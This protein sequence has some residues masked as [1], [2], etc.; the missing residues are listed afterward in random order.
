MRNPMPNASLKDTDSPRAR[1]RVAPYALLACL[2]IGGITAS[3]AQADRAVAASRFY[4]DALVRY[5]RR[6]D[7]GA[8]IQ[9]KNALKEDARMLPALVLLGQAHGRR[10]EYAAAER[11]LADAERLGV[12]RAQIVVHQAEAYFGQGKFRAL[13]EKFGADGLPAAPRLEILLLRAQSQM[14]LNQLDS[15]LGSAQAAEA[16]AGGAARALALQARIHLNAGRPQQAQDSVARAL[17]RAPQDADAWNMQASIAHAAGNLEQALQGYGRALASQPDHLDAR[18]ARAGLLLDLNRDREAW[19]DLEHLQKK[20]A[21]DPRSAYLRALYHSR[22]G[23]EAPA[24]EALVEATRTLSQLPAE[25]VASRDQLQL[26]GGLAHFALNEFE[27]AKGYL[28]Q[29][30][31]VRPREVGARKVLG[32]IYLSEKQYDRAL[33]MLEP[34]LK[35]QPEDAR[36]LS[37]LGSAHMGKGN[38]VRA[39]SLFQEAAQAKDS[40]D[41]QLGLGLSLIGRGQQ[42][43][44]FAA[45]QRAYGQ[46]PGQA[47]TGAPL[48][49]THL[50]RGE[51]GKAVAVMEAVLKREPRNLSARNL[52]G[53]ARLA[54]GDRAGARAAY[55]AVIKASPSFHA[56]QLN[57]GRLDEAEGHAP[58]ARQ[59]YLGVL[60]TDPKHV[61]AMLELARLEETAGRSAEAVRWLEKARSLQARDL[62]PILALSSLYLRQGNAQKALDIAKDAQAIAPEQPD[63]LMTLA[64]A[65]IAVGNIELA[66]VSLK[67]ISQ[68]ASF[69][70]GWLVRVAV[71]QMRAG[72]TE[73]ARYTLGKVVL[74]EPNHL[75]ALIQHIQLDLQT[76]KL[77]D[78]E[79]RITALLEQPHARAEAQSLLGELR[80]RQQRPADALQAFRLAHAGLNTRDSLFGLY[81]ALLVSQQARE[82]AALMQDWSRRQPNDRGARHA[83]GEAWLALKDW[84]RARAVFDGLV[85]SDDRDA[86]AHNNLAHVLLQQR[87]LATALL[88]AEKAYALAPTVP[89][90]N[91]TLGWVLVQQGQAEKGLRYLRDAALRAPDNPEIRAHLNAT[92]KKLGRR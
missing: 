67:R 3:P 1:T 59:R 19:A 40:P 57:L 34:A 21:S 76:G 84:P 45:L 15:A 50:K 60:K 12:A 25:F 49:I 68:L 13:L 70:P 4:E 28:T 72:D 65:Q 92:L 52:L 90:V 64:L 29:Y 77:A 9:L 91:D 37:M 32:A 8:I 7:A 33:A 54:A 47:Q 18:L 27:R 43:D 22:R 16:V 42:D 17:Q 24:R 6:D 11:V 66:R 71:Q 51:P 39:S 55:E 5:E 88:H 56:A 2:L 79:R 61:S 58:R 73:G 62:R 81:R 38:H 14:A 87:E 63:T 10:G 23:D 20:F 86:R 30:L 80:M 44:G 83:L 41:V 53:V 69:D 26:L 48:A 74:A 78:A 82:A 31:N 36:I 85:R 35:A 46:D 89:E 75:P